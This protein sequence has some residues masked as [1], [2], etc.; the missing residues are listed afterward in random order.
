M[1]GRARQA[2][3]TVRLLSGHSATERSGQGRLS[4]A[5]SSGIRSAQLMLSARESPLWGY[6]LSPS[7]RR[8]WLVAKARTPQPTRATPS[9]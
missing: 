6:G 4:A 7:W 5:Q 8:A 9:G 3:V 1:P 2:L